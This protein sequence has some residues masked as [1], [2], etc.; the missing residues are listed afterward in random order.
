MQ[1]QIIVH[2]FG[3]PSITVDNSILRFSDNRSKKVWLLFILLFSR[4]DICVTSEEIASFVW[5]DMDIAN[6][7]NSIKTLVH[8]SRALLD[9]LSPDLGHSLICFTDGKYHINSHDYAVSVDAIEFE[10][11]ISES[12]LSNN[13]DECI[14]KRLAALKLY[15]GDYLPAFSSNT[16]ILAK[17]AF[18]RNQ[19]I[20]C[21]QEMCI[22]LFNSSRFLD[23]IDVCV[24]SLAID[25]YDE[26]INLFLLK[27]F[28]ATDDKP[29]V[30]R[31]YENMRSSL[32]SAFGI[33]PS[34]EATSIYRKA[35]MSDLCSTLCIDDLS[36]NL[37]DSLD[38]KG[39]LFCDYDVFKNIY[40][41]LVRQQVRSGEVYHLVLFSLSGKKSD[42]SKK[43]FEKAF[44]DFINI[45]CSSLRNGD[46]VSMCNSSQLI[47][48]LPQ[49]KYEDSCN[50]SARLISTYYRKYPHSPINISYHIDTTKPASML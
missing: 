45:I 14:S 22:T 9:T 10:K 49:A 12:N 48:L 43:S 1:K 40:Q 37:Q 42:I 21:C 50:V 6:T 16:R 15:S 27:C 31:A 32:Y 23:C 33:I 24:Q 35:T 38:K 7:H 3:E 46:I 28:D 2:F 17:S 30:I 18:L 4:T 19:Y 20:N 41:A 47:V 11:L 36:E 5:D 26:K 44:D 29:S 34:E 25:P 13:T 8:R 39:A